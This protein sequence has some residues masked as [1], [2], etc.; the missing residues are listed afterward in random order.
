M[1]MRTDWDLKS[2]ALAKGLLGKAITEVIPPHVLV[3]MTFN[4]VPDLAE[5]W[6]LLLTF[7]GI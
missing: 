3:K 4:C 7:Y 6:Q 1:R 2:H 5:M